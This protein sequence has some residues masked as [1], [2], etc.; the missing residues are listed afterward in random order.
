METCP[1]CLEILG[2][3]I[4]TTNCNH[5]FCNSCF[6]ELMDNNRIECPLCRGIIKGYLN[7]EGRVRVLL[8][9]NRRSNRNQ[10]GQNEQSLTT[11]LMTINDIRRYRM[12]YYFY[13]G[14]ILYMS[15][16][17]IKSS[18]MIYQLRDLYEGC[19]GRNNNL[20]KIYG[21]IFTSVSIYDI[22][23]NKLSKLCLIPSYYYNKCFNL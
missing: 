6:D 20:T 9:N 21:E 23:L 8:R 16:S 11:P 19:E 2:E 3:N 1:I 10:N 18:Y 7:N 17:L 14:I 15:Y 22:N 5:I 13:I 12:K 4:T